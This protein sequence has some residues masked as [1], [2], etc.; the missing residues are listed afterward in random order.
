MNTITEQTRRESHSQVDKQN[1]YNL[2]MGCIGTREMTARMIAYAL[3]YSDLNAVKPRITE[4]CKK[5]HK[6]EVVGKKKDFITGKM[7][8]VYKAVG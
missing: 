6:L 2:I 5:Y 4:L 3:G 7:V 8:A 1:R